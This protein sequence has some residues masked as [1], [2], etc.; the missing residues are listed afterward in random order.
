M[1]MNWHIKPEDTKASALRK[2]QR[3]LEDQGIRETTIE[4]YSIYIKRLLNFANTDN[5]TRKDVEEFRA[6]LFDRNLSRSTINNHCYAI[7]RYYAMLGEELKLP[8]LKID[9]TIPYYFDQDEIIKIFESCSNIKHLAILKTLFYACLRSSELCNLDDEDLYLDKL[10]IRVRCGK[11]GQD[12]LVPISQDCTKCLKSYLSI[13]PEKIID[14]RQPLFYTDYGN[15]WNRQDISRMFHI[16]KKVAG[17]TKRGGV[18]VF[19]RHSSATL[20]ISRGCSLN[21]VQKVLRH[22]DI[23][24]T[25]RY[26][27]ASETITRDWYNK[28]MILEN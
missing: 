24:S 5:P 6:S 9:N 7:T 25:L 18:H 14:A 26:A 28:T 13:R 19:A 15:R 22:R 20:M 17:I 2:F 1:R 23:R 8:R 12:G 3:Y 21:I 10:M 4:T 27:H 16:Y 11:G